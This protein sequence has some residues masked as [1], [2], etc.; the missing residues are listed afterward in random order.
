MKF[1]DFAQ[2]KI[3]SQS[4]KKKEDQD[5]LQKGVVAV[6]NV[7][8][9]SE[10]KK[11]ANERAINI[12]IDTIQSHPDMPVGE[13]LKMI[14]EKT[15]L[16]DHSLVEII[17]QIPDIKSEKATVEAVKK[18][19][20]ASE[21]ITEI[22]Q[23]APVSPGT[24]QKLAEQIP[25]EEIQK[26]QQA[27]IKRKLK[28]EEEK[29]LLEREKE[30]L[31]QLNNIY[32]TCEEMNDSELIDKINGV[33]INART[34]K[35][36]DSLKNIIAKKIALDCMKF[37][38]PKLP[39]MMKIMPA[40]DMLECNLPVVVEKEYQKAKTIY[41]EKRIEYHEY[42]EERKKLVKRKI[43]ENIAKDVVNNFAEIGD[44]SIPQIESLKN[45]N[46]EEIN[47]F[48][49]EIKASGGKIK[50]S[51]D[52]VDMVRKQ[53]KGDNIGE[54]KKLKKILERMKQSERERAVG[55]FMQILK[56]NKN[57]TQSQKELDDTID[58]IGTKIRKLPSDKQ[59]ETARAICNILEDQYKAIKTEKKSKNQNSNEK[60]EDE[61]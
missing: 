39:T 56:S 4:S 9:E 32:S 17:K 34:E 44:I 55:K 60:G 19:D 52:D 12:V 54:W 43:L 2:K 18:V 3:K 28:E 30:V 22:I 41:E 21:A 1:K 47:I 15:E 53:L 58:D 49:N 26:E 7:Y 11:E 45:L 37:G 29:K 48:T 57:K 38:G 40:T 24:A 42:D 5:K 61:R 13:F 25:D 8:E 31:S 20:L 27:E 14:Q 35:I 6:Q 46:D 23:E 59:L 50:I 51:K 33:G 16:S 10:T 36:N